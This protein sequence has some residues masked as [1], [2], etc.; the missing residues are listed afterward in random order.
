MNLF[1]V[2]CTG[3]RFSSQHHHSVSIDIL[4]WYH[5]FVSFFIEISDGLFICDAIVFD[6]G[7][8]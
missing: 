2:Q 7:D 5:Y 8:I 4:Y 3:H 1:G 6:Y